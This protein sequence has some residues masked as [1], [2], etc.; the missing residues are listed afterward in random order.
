MLALLANPSPLANFFL[1]LLRNVLI[2]RLLSIRLA[3][4]SVVLTIFFLSS[5]FCFWG[6][7][8]NT[9]PMSCY[10]SSFPPK[11]AAL[12]CYIQAPLVWVCTVQLGGVSFIASQS[13][14]LPP[15]QWWW[16]NTIQRSLG[17]GRKSDPFPAHF[18]GFAR[19]HPSCPSRL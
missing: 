3:S 13:P 15:P 14:Y 18:L 12:L 19:G 9:L 7:L 16:Y 1:R 2:K 10:S 5:P 8:I 11:A 17:R 6:Q 4:C